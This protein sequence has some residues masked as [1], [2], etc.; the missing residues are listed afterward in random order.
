MASVFGGALEISCEGDELRS[1]LDVAFEEDDL[2]DVV[3]RA[4]EGFDGLGDGGAVEADDEEL[5]RYVK[6]RG[7]LSGG[8]D[9]GLG[10]PGRAGVAARRRTS[11]ACGTS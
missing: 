5:F 3:G 1:A 8:L 10:L 6:Y 11:R 2:S 4:D 7:V 9:A